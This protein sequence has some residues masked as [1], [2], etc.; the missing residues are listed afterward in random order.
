MLALHI[1]HILNNLLPQLTSSISVQSH[2]ASVHDFILV[3]NLTAVDT[4]SSSIDASTV[5]AIQSKSLSKSALS[6]YHSIWQ[7]THKRKHHRISIRIEPTPR[8][9]SIR[10][11][12]TSTACSVVSPTDQT[13]VCRHV[14]SVNLTVSQQ[15]KDRN[16][17][18]IEFK[19]HSCKDNVG[20]RS[21]GSDPN[22]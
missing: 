2:I 20:F 18:A 17:I 10:V 21:N 12:I 11:V 22:Y 4:I 19:G 6:V 7:C 16:T 13:G 15:A 9:S 5:I 14:T 1:T 8:P 3:S